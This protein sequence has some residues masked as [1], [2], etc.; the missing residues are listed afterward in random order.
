MASARS[1]S[2]IL[3]ALLLA[4]VGPGMAAD[5]TQLPNRPFINGGISKDEADLMR[6]EAPRYPLE[7][8]LARRG[9]TP[10]RNEFVAEAKLRV[11]DGGG[12]VV[13]ERADTGPIFL[14]S[15]PDGTYTVEATLGGQTKTQR[16]DVRNGRHSAVTFLW[17]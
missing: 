12:R 15:L 9:E 10:G 11:L 8:Q 14:A 5:P 16:V 1:G 6:Q 7:V 3:F 17:E 13:L 4:E 2:A